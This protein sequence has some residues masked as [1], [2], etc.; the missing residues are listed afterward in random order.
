M[1]M[2]PFDAGLDHRCHLRLMIYQIAGKNFHKTTEQIQDIPFLDLTSHGL[3]GYL[4]RRYT[5]IS[6]LQFI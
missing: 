3:I 4:Q 6:Q 5:C 2:A 1:T